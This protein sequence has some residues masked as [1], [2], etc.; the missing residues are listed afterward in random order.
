MGQDFEK[1]NH[2]ARI[3]RRLNPEVPR[4]FVTRILLPGTVLMVGVNLL[5]YL[6]LPSLNSRVIN[7]GAVFSMTLWMCYAMNKW[8]ESDIFR[9]E[10]KTE[11]NKD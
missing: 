7:F 5:G 6:F 10:R 1:L 4:G 2:L 8:P 9:S 3:A 11:E